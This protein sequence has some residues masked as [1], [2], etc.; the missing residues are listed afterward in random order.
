ML[1]AVCATSTVMVGN[2]S[3][4]SVVRIGAV[5]S[6]ARADWPLSSALP[7]AAA[8]AGRAAVAAGGASN[9]ISVRAVAVAF[10]AAIMIS[11]VP[12]SEAGGVYFVAL[13][14]YAVIM[15]VSQLMRNHESVVMIGIGKREAPRMRYEKGHKE[16]T[17]QH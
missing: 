2:A 13:R 7:R 10:W 5:S 6:A 15:T 3:Y 1:T 12:A 4:N 11:A 8:G 17:P 16:A 14:S 9:S